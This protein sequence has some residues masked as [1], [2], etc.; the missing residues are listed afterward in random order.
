MTADFNTDLVDINEINLKVSK[1][2]SLTIPKNFVNYGISCG[3]LP[4]KRE[5]DIVLYRLLRISLNTPSC[6]TEL[7][8]PPRG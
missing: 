4:C 7:T 5:Q 6:P 3:K 1:L 8:L 2:L